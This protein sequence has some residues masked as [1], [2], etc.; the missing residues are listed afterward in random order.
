MIPREFD[1]ITKEDVEALVTNAVAEGRTIE[2]KQ[3]LPG[4]SDEEKREFLA[5]VSSFANAGGGD[6]IYG[7]VEKRDSDNKP[8]GIP[9][10][11]EGLPGINT[12]SEI[13]RLDESIRSAID[14]RIPGYHIRGIDGLPA[15]PAILI[16]IP[17]SWASP[18]MVT[19]KKGSRFFAR[20]SAGKYQ[21]DVHEIRSA[22]T[23]SGDLRA[24]ISA[25]RTDRLGKIIANEAPISLP[26]A[27]KIIL[28]LVP[29]TILDPGTQF[30]LHLLDKDPNLAAPIQNHSYGQRFNLDGFL[31][32][33]PSGRTGGQRGYVQVFRSG[34]IEA[35]DAEM[36]T[37]P[38]GSKLVPSQLVEKKIITATARYLK[39]AQQLGVPPPLVVMVTIH[40][41]KDYAMA[42]NS[43]WHNFNPVNA[44]DRDML[45]LPDVLLEEF[46]T[47]ADRL[48]KPVFDA[49]WQSAGFSSCE[50][51][52]NQGRW[53]GG[54]SRLPGAPG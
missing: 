38:D 23:A 30:D 43:P 36:F 25:F 15:G 44:I 14:P 9:E 45:L 46:T 34:A 19:F 41:L 16:R 10:K 20:T 27:P 29:L 11:A 52:N 8:T 54:M 53:D 48:L 24:R 17:K 49:F 42:T 2:Y 26:A 47:P 1:T 13:R 40:G 33:G 12:D 51:Y 7:V 32:Y 18:H 22:F 21:L 50:N 28:H 31:G 39:T 35:V 6:I 5:D 4:N 3:Q 37:Q